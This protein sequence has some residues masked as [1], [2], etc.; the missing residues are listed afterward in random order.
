MGFNIITINREFASRGSEIAQEV[1]ARLQIPYVDKFLITE[2]AAKSGFSVDA[3][4]A[5]DEQLASRFEYSQAEAAHYYTASDS[6]LPTSAQIAE[7]QFQLIR[8][9]SEK[10]PCLIVGRCA[11]YL[12]RERTDVLDVFVHAGRDYRVQATM[13]DL[14]L[15]ERS[16]VRLLRRTDKARKAYYRNYTGMDWNDPNSYH[17]VLNSDRLTQEVCVDLICRAYQEP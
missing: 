7:V 11:N 1:A 3:I 9:L 13:K 10:G 17:M 16:A 14:Q 15:S 12:L 6:P 8:E 4:T 2:S 5:T